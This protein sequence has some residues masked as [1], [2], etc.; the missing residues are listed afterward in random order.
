MTS[1]SFDDSLS[2]ESDEKTRE[3]NAHSEII[4]LN[5]INLVEHSRNN[6]DK[7]ISD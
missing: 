3:E 7:I 5:S 6:E 2:E 4:V 1:P